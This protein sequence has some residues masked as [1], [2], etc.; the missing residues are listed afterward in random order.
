[1]TERLKN[2]VASLGALQRSFWALVSAPM[3]V[4]QA[5]AE[6]PQHAWLIDAIHADPSAAVER[7]GV[8]ASMYFFRLRDNLARDFPRLAGLL[9]DVSFHNLVTDYLWACSSRNPSVR[10]LGQSLPSFLRTHELSQDRPWL[11]EL[12][13]LEWT[14]L[15]VFDRVDELVL[16]ME[17]LQ[18]AAATGFEGLTL[19]CIAAHQI[20]RATHAIEVAWRELEAPD[21]TQ[22]RSI[23]VWRQ[24]DLYVYHRVLDRLEAEVMPL[25]E[26]G[27]AFIELCELLAAKVP[28]QVAAERALAVLSEWVRIGLLVRA[29]DGR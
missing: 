15:D 25:A 13:E 21:A 24:P 9:G 11:A 12:A 20:V 28:A 14:R 16:T 18:Q 5:L 6:A 29:H 4:D 10:Y 23:L 1:M 7:L 17:D 27:V 8:Y 22:T 3:E 26:R 2:S 19:R